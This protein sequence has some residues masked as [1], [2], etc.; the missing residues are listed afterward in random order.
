MTKT[1]VLLKSHIWNDDIEKFAIKIYNETINFGIDFFLLLV[2]NDNIP[3][4]EKIKSDT[5][6]NVTIKLTE[7]NIK[8]VYSSGFF[9]MWMSNHW[10]L[11]WFYKK[12][13]GKYQYFWSVEY[14]V[15]ISGNS[16]RIW[17]YNSTLDFLY[18]QGNF[19]H[20]RHIFKDQYVGGKMK[21]IDKFYGFLQLA[22]YSHRAL[23]Y[24]D[25][26]FMRGE[27]GQDELIIF[28]LLNRAKLTGSKAFLG[29]LMGGRWTWDSK[30]IPINK[31]TYEKAESNLHN[32]HLLIFH[33][34]K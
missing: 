10:I 18:P 9:S 28:S 20:T 13:V 2:T 12:Y 29:S 30:Y 17:N 26:C 16:T 31:E 15:R 32:N 23:A 14:D 33:P 8:N 24:L 11:M 7:A 3:T 6:K 19:R 27:N 1:V 22:R 4:F 21:D 25:S 5:I 34:I